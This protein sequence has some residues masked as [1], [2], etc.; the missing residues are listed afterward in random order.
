MGPKGESQQHKLTGEQRNLPTPKGGEAGQES[1][2]ALPP[3]GGNN[4]NLPQRGEQQHKAT[5]NLTESVL[6]DGIA[7]PGPYP[8]N[9]EQ[10]DHTPQ[11]GEPTAQI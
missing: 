8:P 1:H 3:K 4:E 9:G 5:Q 7:D 10:R 6:R 2:S 11:R